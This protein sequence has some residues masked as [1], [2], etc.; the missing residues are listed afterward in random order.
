MSIFYN[1]DYEYSKRSGSGLFKRFKN[2][3]NEGY[4]GLIETLISNSV[5]NLNEDGMMYYPVKMGAYSDDYVKVEEFGF[6]GYEVSYMKVKKKYSEGTA[7]LGEL[8]SSLNNV[9]SFSVY[10]DDALYNK[11]HEDV[12]KVKVVFA[13]KD[14]EE[15]RRDIK[16]FKELNSKTE[17]ALESLNKERKHLLKKKSQS[18]YDYGVVVENNSC[19][20][21]TDEELLRNCE[22]N[23]ETQEGYKQ[24]NDRQLSILEE[25]LKIA[26]G[27]KDNSI[28]V[29]EKLSDL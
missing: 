3:M 9:Y 2:K 1:E 10:D 17:E 21:F 8:N 23:I 14:I 16:R 4:H 13:D 27:H 18:I 15:I 7:G 28:R 24:H 5:I 22:C 29:V 25:K 19:L 12:L 6:D 11:I 26:K 20:M